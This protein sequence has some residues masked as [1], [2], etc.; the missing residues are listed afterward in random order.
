[1]TRP[2][3]DEQAT[4]GLNA[5]RGLHLMLRFAALVLALAV[6]MALVMLAIAKGWL[7]WVLAV[8]LG[9]F[10]LLVGRRP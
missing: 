2:V 1:M 8:V 5:A 7:V 9:A 10:V 3:W 6:V 4:E